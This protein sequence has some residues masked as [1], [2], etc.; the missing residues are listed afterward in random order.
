MDVVYQVIFLE[1]GDL[2]EEF[3][4][5]ESAYQYASELNSRFGGEIIYSVFKWVNE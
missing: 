3:Y 4:D 1:G 2:I 5:E